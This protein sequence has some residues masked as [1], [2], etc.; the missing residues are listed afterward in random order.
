MGVGRPEEIVSAVKAGIDMFDC[1][2]P[3]REARHGRL[4]TKTGHMDIRK[5]KYVKDKKVIEKSRKLE[6]VH[7][8][9]DQMKEQNWTEI[10]ENLEPEDFGKYKM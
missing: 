5:G 6:S 1:V 8:S 2:I 3:T 7:Q 10:L 4:Y 9:E